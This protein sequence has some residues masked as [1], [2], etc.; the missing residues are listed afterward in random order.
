MRLQVVYVLS[1]VLTLA[2]CGERTSKGVV[3]ES[4]IEK[5]IPGDTVILAGVQFTELQDTAAY[6]RLAEQH[7]LPQLE[8]FSKRTKLDVR[9]DLKELVL[10]SNGKES[11]MM[12][13]GEFRNPA[14]LEAMLE[15]E[16][17]KRI[18]A[19][20]VTLFG[21]EQGAVAFLGDL[22][23]AGKIGHLKTVLSGPPM[24]DANK[25]AVLVK[26]AS[27]P[28]E[29]QVWAV[30]VGGFAPMPLPETGNLANLNRVFRSMETA[31]LTLDFTKGVNL[32]A[33]GLCASEKD[34]RQIH[35][36]LRG[37]VGFGRLSTPSDQLEM[38][39]FF[40][41]I[42]IDHS[43][44]QVKLNADVPMDMLEKFLKLTERRRPAA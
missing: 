10:A 36:L 12:A 13:R 2:G 22:A 25:R 43:D 23:I 5:L 27:L 39:R 16:G 18:A 24:D 35:D 38:L 17:A 44:R 40:D 34:A 28:R 15:K 26:A 31:A 29:R 3:L 6:K 1:M 30:A 4:S 20:N 9:K 33:T 19:G 14:E 21:D 32:S 7:L 37:L 8:E 41:A 11:V 42:K